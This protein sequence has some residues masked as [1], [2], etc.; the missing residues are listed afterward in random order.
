MANTRVQHEV[1]EWIRTEF[2]PGVYDQGFSKKN[3]Q[4]RPGGIF[5]FD[6]VSEDG[7][8]AASIS[9]ASSRTSSGKLASGTM[10]KIRSD[11]LFLTMVEVRKPL[12]VF[13]QADLLEY[14]KEQSIRGRAPTSIEYR[15]ARVLGDLGKRLAQA[16][17][18]A[19]RE[20]S[21]E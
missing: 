11:M 3:L 18:A 20:M 10:N 16:K 7:R 17:G 4:L 15:L 13:T 5:E 21:T 6:A 2:L 1:E 14:W 9:T 19:S 8:I 12:L